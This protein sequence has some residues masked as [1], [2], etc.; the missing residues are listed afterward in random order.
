LTRRIM[1]VEEKLKLKVVSITEK[2]IRYRLSWKGHVKRR[3]EKHVTRR[4]MNMNVKNGDKEVDLRK[5]ENNSVSEDARKM[6]DK[7]RMSRGE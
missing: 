2:L 1:N 4:V 5:D 3:E 6:N 7:I